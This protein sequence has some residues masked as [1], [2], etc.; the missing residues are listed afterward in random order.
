M[1]SL[2]EDT[3]FH[4]HRKKKLTGGR[5]GSLAFWDLKA[6][7][8]VRRVLAHDGHLTTLCPVDEVLT[9]KYNEFTWKRRHILENLD[10]R[11]KFA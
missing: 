2:N 6:A 11:N 5:D 9:T 1:L 7:R 10:F 3:A 8:L 4:L